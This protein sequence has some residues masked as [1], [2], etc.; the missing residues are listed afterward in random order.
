MLKLLKQRICYYIINLP[1]NVIEFFYQKYHVNISQK[2]IIH[3][4]IIKSFGE[5]TENKSGSK[6]LAVTLF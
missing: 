3:V 4:C 1:L 5:D 6:A 2:A